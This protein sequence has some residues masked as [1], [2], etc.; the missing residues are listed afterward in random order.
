MIVGAEKQ[1]SKD[2]GPTHRNDVIQDLKAESFS[3]IEQLRREIDK[4]IIDDM[5]QRFDEFN[6]RTAT[7]MDEVEKNLAVNTSGPV[8]PIE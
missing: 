8:G 6:L 1:E 7:T 3:A 2:G 5:N 4:E